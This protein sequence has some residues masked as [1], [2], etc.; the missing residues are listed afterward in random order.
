MGHEQD[1]QS[2]P[3]DAETK[4]KLHRLQIYSHYLPDVPF[5]PTA[6]SNYGFH[7][8]G[9]EQ[10]DKEDIGLEGAINRQLKIQL[11]HQTNGLVLKE[12]VSVSCQCWRIQWDLCLIGTHHENILCSSSIHDR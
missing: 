12:K 7:F 9:T 5:M 10:E 6:K 2:L 8:F 1:T 3:M 4:H 11:G